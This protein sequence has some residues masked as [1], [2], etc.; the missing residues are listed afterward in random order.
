MP[1]KQKQLSFRLSDEEYKKFQAFL[2]LKGE[3]KF[4]NAAAK[5]L[6]LEGLEK[7]VETKNLNTILHYGK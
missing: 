3:F 2:L 5:F 6:F 1:S 4:N 7:H